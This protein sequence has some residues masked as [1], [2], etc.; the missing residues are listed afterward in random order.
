MSLAKQINQKLDEILAL[1]EELATME[2][3]LPKDAVLTNKETGDEMS[4][5]DAVDIAHGVISKVKEDLSTIT[6]K[7]QNVS[8]IFTNVYYVNDPMEDKRVAEKQMEKKLNKAKPN[9]ID[10]N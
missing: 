10:S 2:S 9:N 5:D 8:D 7:G 4:V 6:N 1:K 3:E